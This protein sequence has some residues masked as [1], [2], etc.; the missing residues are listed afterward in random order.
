MWM[1]MIQRVASVTCIPIVT[2]RGSPA[3]G[4]RF[5]FWPFDIAIPATNLH[6]LVVC[7]AAM[8]CICRI[9]ETMGEFLL[10]SRLKDAY[11]KGR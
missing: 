2:A 1:S 3:T 11:V 9:R 4:A 8:R 10:S 7:N 6:Q 5:A